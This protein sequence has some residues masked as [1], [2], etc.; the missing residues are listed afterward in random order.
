MITLSEL[1]IYPI[2]SCAQIS[3]TK[4]TLGPFGLENDRRWMLIDNQGYMLTQRKLSRMCL[5]QC[6]VNN[7]QITLSAPG[8]QDISATPEDT[9]LKATVWEDNCTALDCGNDVAQWLSQFLDTETRLVYFPATEIRQVDLNYAKQ[10]DI[11][12]FSDG[13][14]YLLISQASLDDLNS[15]LQHPVEMKRFRPN[16]VIGGCEAF[17][18]DNWKQVR[19]GDIEFDIVKPC[20]RCVIP[21]IDPAT[22]EKSAEP[23]KTLTSYRK[24]DNKIFFGQNVIAR[25]NNS[26]KEAILEVGMPV[27][28]IK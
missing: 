27:E 22:S 12:A 3:L 23:V 14:P 21:S 9:Q 19:I 8:M 13:F 7:Q 18:E 1:A 26:Q 16:L 6:S 20:S 11:T 10:G 24:R 5:I 15:R 25:N 4:A 2:K 17:E 28:I